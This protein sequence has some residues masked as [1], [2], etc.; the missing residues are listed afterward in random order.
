MTGP[1]PGCDAVRALAPEVALGALAGT[2]RAAVL[3][4]LA[5]CD[6]CRDVV[7]DL[8]RVA[9]RLLLAAPP[10]E[11]PPGFESRVLD[12]LAET[13]APVVRAPRWRRLVALAAA[14]VLVL[15][16]MAAGWVAAGADD[17]GPLVAAPMQDAEGD[18][19]GR[20]FLYDGEQAW[21]FLTVDGWSDAW[22]AVPYQVRVDLVDGRRVLLDGAG[23][24]AGG[25]GWGTT[26]DLDP[27]DVRWVGV[28]DPS[29]RVWCGARL[30]DA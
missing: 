1:A 15:A 14:V 9:D 5:G 25:G 20:V 18:D 6:A 24:S 29:G 2:E 7:A 16:G 10:A 3:A 12:R 30:R 23:L 22:G 13:G 21:M 28:V 27:D 8:S 19:V 4:H 26:V 11:P 17:P